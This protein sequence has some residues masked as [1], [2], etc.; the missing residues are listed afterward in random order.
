MCDIKI[1]AFAGILAEHLSFFD[2]LRF[3]DKFSTKLYKSCMSD[4]KKF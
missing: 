2:S 4:A 1:S 3:L